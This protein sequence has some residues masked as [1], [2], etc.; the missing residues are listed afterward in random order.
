MAV[1]SNGTSFEDL[2]SDVNFDNNEHKEH[3]TIQMAPATTHGYNANVAASDMQVIGTQSLFNNYAVFR[4]GK[5]DDFSDLYDRPGN[6][7]I[8]DYESR[9]PSAANIINHSQ[10]SQFAPYTLMDFIY[11]K[12]YAM[13]PNNNLLTLRRFPIP[14]V[15]NMNPQRPL[16]PIAQAV[17]FMGEE[18]G[19]KLSEFFK[20]TFGQNWKVLEAKVQEVMGNEKDFKSA[21]P[22]PAGSIGGLITG[23][24]N[25]N[26]YSL[27]A[28]AQ[29]EYSRSLYTENYGPYGNK[30]YGPVQVIDKTYVRDRG[31]HFD[32]EIKLNFHYNL[33]SYGNI[34]PK[35]A[36]L[37]L[38]SNFLTLTYNNAK[39]WGGAIRYF[40]AHPQ[41]PFFGDQNAFYNGDLDG[42]IGSVVAQLGKIGGTLMDSFSKF[43]Q[44]PMTALKE[45]ATSFAKH[46]AG[47]IAARDR[48]QIISMQSLLTGAPVGEWHL[49]IGNPLNPIA[50]I[51]NLV[52]TKV[53]MEFGDVLGADDF[54]TEV[55]FEV[56][57]AH[58][59]PRDKG[60]IESML[61]NGNGRM[62]YGIKDD[63]IFSSSRNSV[64]D[65][66]GTKG[67]TDGVS[68]NSNSAVRLTTREAAAKVRNLWPQ[69][70][71]LQLQVAEKWVGDQPIIA[72]NNTKK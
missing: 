48:P 34:N 46:Q 9:N 17:T 5:S 18:P 12:Y 30:L 59:R 10:S 14:I 23:I 38:V 11:C 3:S 19:N 39:F 50:M 52:C 36:M 4:Y 56:T 25:P 64:V 35:I 28:Q 2:I 41:R 60:D 16:A 58:G 32:N 68:Q 24:Q 53:E 22:G 44:D 62:Y 1:T 63:L 49:T 20:F 51:G 61:N 40:P 72:D 66:S 27:L 21:I 69:F 29:T 31:M 65:T 47:K 33:K 71:G 67:N 26:E 57:L 6:Q 13:I 37:D 15:D 45:L 7:A 70:K 54:P 55:K 8:T 42:Y 43:L